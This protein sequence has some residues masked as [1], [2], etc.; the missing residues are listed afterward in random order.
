MIGHRASGLAVALV[1]LFVVSIR[2]LTGED[3]AR[4]EAALALGDHRESQT[5]W[6]EAFRLAMASR[7]AEGLLAVGY[8]YVRMGQAS[9][10][11]G[12]ALPRARQLFLS[13]LLQAEGRR[14]ANGVTAAAE[15]FASIGDH[16]V[17]DRACD[18]ALPLAVK[19]ND[20]N[21]RERV[22]A[23]RS[24]LRSARQA[25]NLLRGDEV[26]PTVAR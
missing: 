14:D 23:L 5:A 12:K 1:A 3:L 25:Q 15:A 13:A 24:K 20:G 22:M 7:A 26:A 11:R 9:N 10:D 16:E 21:A 2:A 6:E 4:A 19:N 8:A 17:A 18:I